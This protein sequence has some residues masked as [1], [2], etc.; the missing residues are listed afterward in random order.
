MCSLKCTANIVPADA[1]LNCIA[2]LWHLTGY[3]VQTWTREA[4]Q[5]IVLPLRDG[6]NGNKKIRNKKDN[7]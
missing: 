4:G 6:T 2:L 3:I 1:G 5:E 7:I